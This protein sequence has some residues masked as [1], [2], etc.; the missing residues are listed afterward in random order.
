MG[1][2][3]SERDRFHCKYGLWALFFMLLVGF[4][5][6]R[7]HLGHK[8]VTREEWG[9]LVF[10]LGVLGFDAGCSHMHAAKFIGVEIISARGEV[11]TSTW[12]SGAGVALVQLF[13]LLALYCFCGF[14]HGYLLS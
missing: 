11:R 9:G 1:A 14:P 13:L 10:F 4:G 7:E 2:G 6:E 5:A 3:G 8:F 12:P